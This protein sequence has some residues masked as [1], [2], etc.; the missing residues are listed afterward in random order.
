MPKIKVRD[1]ELYYEWHG[2]E[3]A[4][5]LILLNGVLMSTAS[6]AFQ[7][8]VLSQKYHLLLHDCRGQGQSDH[9]TTPYSM[10]GHMEDL[11]GL[12]DALGIEKAH[13]AGISY[14]GEIALLAGIH[15]PERVESLF[16]SSSVSEV[17][18]ALRGVIESWI[19]CAEKGDGALLYRCSV[20]DN[21]SEGWLARYPNFA[22]SSIPRY[23]Q[24]DMAAVIN[25][26]LAFL[27][28]DCTAELER[29]S[30]PTM[31]VVGEMDTLKPPPYSRLIAER[32]PGAG[33][34]LLANAG[35]ACCLEVPAAWNAALLGFLAEVETRGG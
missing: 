15:M 25:L 33:L 35:H 31:V 9:P 13:L 32:I 21:F 28:L 27:G 11:R 18:P 24:L 17:R 19:A 16:V 7:T 22:A 5:V 2:S 10:E 34:M 29:I 6:W 14:G 8:H 1:I 20:T 23:E 30:A 4:P 26:C 12:M 3:D